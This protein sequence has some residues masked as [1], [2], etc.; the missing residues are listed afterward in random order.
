MP[1]EAAQ[2]ESW[3]AK[4]PSALAAEWR[5]TGFGAYGGGVLWTPVPDQP[6]LNPND[7]GVLDGTGVEVLRTAFASVCVWQGGQFLWLNVHTGNVTPF[8]PSAEILFDAVLP[9]KNFR[10]QVLLT[11]LYQHACSRYGKL[12]PDECFGFAPL[13]NFGGATSEEYLI[14]TPMRGYVAMLAQVLDDGKV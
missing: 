6:F 3:A 14:K 5:N 11:S 1:F 4:V 7:W 2:H 12:E 8:Y 10:K 9:E 13:P